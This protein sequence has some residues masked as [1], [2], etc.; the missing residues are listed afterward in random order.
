V[1]PVTATLGVVVCLSMIYGLGWTN[2]A[3]LIVWLLLGFIIYFGYSRKH[4]LLA[5]R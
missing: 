5:R 3:R 1:L 4:S 2:W